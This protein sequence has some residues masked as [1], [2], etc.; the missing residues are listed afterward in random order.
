MHPVNNAIFQHVSSGLA[1]GA[2]ILQ[3]FETKSDLLSVVIPE[4]LPN[5]CLAVGTL[6]FFFL[7]CF[8]T[9]AVS[10][11]VVFLGGPKLS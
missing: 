8:N 2:I 7:W 11:K 5:A 10:Q 6:M 3:V 1:S 4:E 9:Y